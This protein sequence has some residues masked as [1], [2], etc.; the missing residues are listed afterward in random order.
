MAAKKAKKKD[1]QT[2]DHSQI[3]Y[4]E[5]RKDFYVESPELA[6]MTD[7]EVNL[8]RAELDNIKIRGVRCPKP[9]K[10]WTHCG[11]P[12]QCEHVIK[13]LN[14]GAPTAIQ[15]Q[16]IPA[17]MS[18]R[19]VIGVARTGSGKTMAFLLPMFRHIKDQRPLENMEG[20][21]AVI[22]TPTRELAM[23]IHSECKRFTKIMNMRVNRSVQS[24]FFCK[25]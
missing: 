24:F 15:A 4:E 21:I 6:R 16:A 11:L 5:F 19:D 7:M 14:F 23:Q 25:Y 18:G 12:I 13:G 2:V 17:I 9:V 3:A 1:L 22:M 8:I 10:K 20:P